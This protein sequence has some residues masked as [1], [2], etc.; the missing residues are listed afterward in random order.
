MSLRR[1]LLDATMRKRGGAIL[2][3]F[4]VLPIYLQEVFKSSQVANL[5]FLLSLCF[6]LS[7]IN[8]LVSRLHSGSHDGS[9]SADDLLHS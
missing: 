7:C 2:V 3:V 9:R 4:T 6:S 5:T 1:N 8:L